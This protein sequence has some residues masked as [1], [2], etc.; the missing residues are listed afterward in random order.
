MRPKT[1][2]YY[3]DTCDVRFD[4]LVEFDARESTEC[5]TCNATCQRSW[6]GWSP[7]MN[8]RQSATMVAEVGK[9]RFKTLREQQAL[10]KEK[11]AARERNDRATEKLI[12]REKKKL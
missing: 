5:P 3:C 4:K 8:T 1:Y 10:N 6:S 2:V 11:A 7:T 12:D 9:G